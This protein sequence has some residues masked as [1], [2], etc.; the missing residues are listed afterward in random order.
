[1]SPYWWLF[2]LRFLSGAD[3]STLLL[4]KASNDDSEPCDV[5]GGGVWCSSESNP[6]N[7]LR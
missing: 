3:A 4:K 1:M 7:G 5:D 2:G 6:R